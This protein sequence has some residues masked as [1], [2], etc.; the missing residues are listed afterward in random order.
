MAKRSIKKILM[1]CCMIIKD[2]PKFQIITDQ[3]SIERYGGNKMYFAPPI[4]YDEVME[5]NPLWKSDYCRKD[6]RIL[7]GVERS[8]LY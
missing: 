8:G 6:T 7:C 1:L 5:K 2:M 3:K 4:D